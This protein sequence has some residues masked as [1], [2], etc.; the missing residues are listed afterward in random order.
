MYDEIPLNLDMEL[1]EYQDRVESL[2]DEWSYEKWSVQDGSS[3][4]TLMYTR[5]DHD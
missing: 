3:E 2:M 1:S 4:R 5:R